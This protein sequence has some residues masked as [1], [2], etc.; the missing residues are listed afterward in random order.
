ME[1][2]IEY[3]MQT[4]DGAWRVEVVK[5]GRSRWY[6]IRHGDNELD[7]LSIAAVHRVL[8]DA[9][10]DLADLVEAGGPA[11]P[12]PPGDAQHGVA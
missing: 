4:P 6:R 3:A 9:G 11:N 7:W 10:I 2:V 8:G 12:A 1:A 5:R